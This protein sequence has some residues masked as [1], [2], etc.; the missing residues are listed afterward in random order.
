M[1]SNRTDS[2]RTR[3][4]SRVALGIVLLFSATGAD[5]GR[6]SIRIDFGAWGVAQTIDLWTNE[7]TCPWD[8]GVSG[9]PG[10]YLY[11]FVYRNSVVFQ[12]AQFYEPD[13]F[14]EGYCQLSRPYQAGLA[15]DEYLNKAAFPPEERDLAHMIGA[16]TNNAVS[17]VRFSF[18][19]DTS[20][21]LIGRQWAFYF[22]PD[23]LMVVGLYGVPDDGSTY[24]AEGIYDQI[25]SEWV[26][27][28]TVDGFDGQYFCFQDGEYIGDC[29]PPAPPPPEEIFMNSFEE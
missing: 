10:N 22:F 11:A 14:T 13:S 12:T 23:N 21:G 9:D 27:R 20:S 29:V 4:F 16:N 26:W 15:T 24:P 8:S 3:S 1:A 6:R 18:L 2:R 19:A 25:A 7:S 28:S 17:A 5:A